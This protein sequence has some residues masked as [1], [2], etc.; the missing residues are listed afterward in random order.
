MSQY[1]KTEQ[2]KYIKTINTGGS[3]VEITVRDKEAKI[4]EKE[5]KSG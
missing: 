2:K 1:M 5:E 4:I 3:S